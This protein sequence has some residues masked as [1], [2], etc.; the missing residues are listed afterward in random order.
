MIRRLFGWSK[1]ILI[2]DKCVTEQRTWMDQD[3]YGYVTTQRGTWEG[4]IVT[5]K[6]TNS[7]T[8]KIR[9]KYEEFG[10]RI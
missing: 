6:S 3:P 9:Y 4:H 7:R 10:N 5:Y 2:Q 8:G 1:W